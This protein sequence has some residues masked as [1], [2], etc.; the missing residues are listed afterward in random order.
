MN[1]CST[2]SPEIETLPP[3][4]NRG[5]TLSGTTQEITSTAFFDWY[6]A[7]LEIDDIQGLIDNANQFFVCDVRR[8]TPD[9]PYTSAIEVFLG[10]NVIFKASYGG[11]NAGVFVKATGDQSPRF[12]QFI[13]KYYP[14]HGVSRMD[15]AIDFDEKGDFETLMHMA[16]YLCETFNL[17][18]KQVGDFRD[19]STSGRTIYVGSRKSVIYMRIYEKGKQQRELGYD[20]EASLNWARL[21]IE[22]KPAKRENKKRAATMQPQDVF[23]L[24]WAKEVARLL[25]TYNIGKISLGTKRVK[26]DDLDKKLAYMQY[27]YTA[28]IREVIET[29]LGGDRTKLGDYLE[30]NLHASLELIRAAKTHIEQ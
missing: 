17:K 5:V 9:R 20:P 6:A 15:S 25:G 24:G 30:S 7:N 16:Q 8:G 2:N 23:A 29:R 3:Y 26:N 1:N 28:V 14:D 19:G 22:V 21:E 18:Y 13:R 10:K 12:S 27:Q 11:V 4:T